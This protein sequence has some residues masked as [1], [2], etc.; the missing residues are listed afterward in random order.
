MN[1][2]SKF[3]FKVSNLREIDI[4]YDKVKSFIS[5]IHNA[6]TRNSEHIHYFEKPYLQIKMRED[7]VSYEKIK[8]IPFNEDHLVE[9]TKNQIF[10]FDKEV[11]NDQ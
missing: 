2:T 8:H 7:A 4:S 9:C 6:D 5:E 1:K 10:E 11:I 3:F